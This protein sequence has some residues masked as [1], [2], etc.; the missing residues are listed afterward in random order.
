MTILCVSTQ[1][2]P[3]SLPPVSEGLWK[4]YVICSVCVYA[5]MCA[6]VC[7]ECVRVCVMSVYVCVWC[8]FA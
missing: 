2:A 8:V 6:C 3:P 1:L 4:G 5:R 7:D